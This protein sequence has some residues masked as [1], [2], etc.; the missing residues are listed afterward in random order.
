VFK[1]DF[2]ANI[3]TLVEFNL[4]GVEASPLPYRLC[5]ANTDFTPTFMVDLAGVNIMVRNFSYTVDHLFAAEEQYIT[6]ILDDITAFSPGDK[7]W[8]TSV[9][10]GDFVGHTECGTADSPNV[11]QTGTVTLTPQHFST[12]SITDQWQVRI[13]VEGLDELYTQDHLN[14]TSQRS[15]FIGM[16]FLPAGSDSTSHGDFI[17]DQSSNFSTFTIDL[18]GSESRS[19]FRQYESEDAMYFF[20]GAVALQNSQS[21]MFARG[22]KLGAV[23][24]MKFPN[25]SL[26]F[27]NYL[28]NPFWD[29]SNDFAFTNTTDQHNISV[30]DDRT[31]VFYSAR[32]CSLDGTTA[33][34]DINNTQNSTLLEHVGG[35]FNTQLEELYIPN[36]EN[37]TAFIDN[38]TTHF[39]YTQD[40]TQVLL[41]KD[42]YQL[43]AL[44]GPNT[45]G[46]AFL[47][48]PYGVYVTDL[49]IQ[50]G[51]SANLD[52]VGC[53]SPANGQDVT[54]SVNSN[55]MFDANSDL[56]F[57]AL[58]CD[59]QVSTKTSERLV[60]PWVP[61]LS[62]ND[63]TYANGQVSWTQQF[64]FSNVGYKGGS[65]FTLCVVK[66]DGSFMDF[67]PLGVQVSPIEI[68]SENTRT[69]HFAPV[70]N[71][72]LEIKVPDFYFTG[73]MENHLTGEMN[74]RNLSNFN[75]SFFFID[76][77]NEGLTC[78]NA[79]ES[80]SP[81]G[82]NFRS[83]VSTTEYI[84]MT[85]NNSFTAFFDLTKF[86][87]SKR[88]HLCVDMAVDVT[89]SD[90]VT[91]MTEIY[92]PVTFECV[93]I[94]FGV[95]VSTDT[96][97]AN[98]QQ[99]MSITDTGSTLEIDDKLVW[100]KE[101]CSC[102]DDMNLT[103]SDPSCWSSP[104]NFAT[105]GGVLEFD[106]DAS[107]SGTFPTTAF[108][109]VVRVIQPSLA[110]RLLLTVVQD[111]QI[112]FA[113]KSNTISVTKAVGVEY[114]AVG[115]LGDPHV[116]A[117]DGSWLDF[118]GEAGVYNLLQNGNVQANAKFGYA[119][120][121]DRMLWHPKVMRPGTLIEE[122]GLHLA[123]EKVSLRLAVH[124]G[125]LVSV[126]QSTDATQFWTG[127]DDRVLQV[128]DYTIT[129]AACQ[130]K[131]EVPWGS[132]QRV[133]S[134]TV[135]GRGEFLQM[136]V[137]QSGGYSF[138]D[139]EVMPQDDTTGLLADAHAAPKALANRLM[140]GGEVDY[141]V[142]ISAMIQ[143]F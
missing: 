127:A 66:E 98:D 140:S 43:C 46:S 15:T 90:G 83:A 136:F 95:D 44:I 35:V 117:S 126:R 62:A 33:N 69:A 88:G 96:V 11:N 16:C 74:D 55:L 67:S 100:V 125:G 58:G 23:R 92:T 135:E 82:N 139:V 4:T 68:F 30:P 1:V 41:S 78:A 2:A 17:V 7:L 118:Y 138:V 108:L 56:F 131:V 101:G 32:G 53:V 24:Q 142:S 128:G 81:I 37:A 93:T 65:L 121:D 120:R 97:S 109:C 22:Y 26:S 63:L 119:V 75:F 47:M 105:S 73:E 13:I 3:S 137:A 18:E 99:Q 124:G 102:T 114:T 48:S 34:G 72:S 19:L 40:F 104:A 60:T 31:Y 8:F 6:M 51:S 36:S 84:D 76:S 10:S 130:D 39:T 141:R 116:R 29:Y 12:S 86:N 25:N 112:A 103:E 61:L 5:L 113:L 129:W 20:G 91:N 115:I 107:M 111:V 89:D 106:F 85:Q 45:N 54:F 134:L 71:Q 50:G 52:T 57:S 59:V 133:R 77:D 87:Q 28:D 64:D 110:R 27:S 80:A 14:V 122:V 143:S 49:T 70:M 21:S 42:L 94:E 132:H 9:G 38:Q 123:N 79:K